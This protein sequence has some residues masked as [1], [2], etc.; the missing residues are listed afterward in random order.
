MPE[1]KRKRIGN[2]QGALMLG[3]AGTIDGVQFLL[4]FIPII[5]WIFVS[6][7]SIFAWL[8]F[9]TWFKFNGIGFLRGKAAI[10][11]LTALMGV[12]I[13]EIIP[14]INDIPAWIAFVGIMLIIRI[15]DVGISQIGGL[16]KFAAKRMG[17][18]ANDIPRGR[19]LIRIARS[20]RMMKRVL[21]ETGSENFAYSNMRT[22]KIAGRNI[23]MKKGKGKS[24][25]LVKAAAKGALRGARKAII[26]V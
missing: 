21:S 24:K 10:L 23:S 13:T 2:M 15:E 14:I 19:G 3:V 9:F 20:A 18:N 7:L 8:T 5:G 4:N 17:I 12:G 22:N 26:K 16:N 11:R 25:G 1:E 6:L